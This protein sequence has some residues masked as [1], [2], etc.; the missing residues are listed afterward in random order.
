MFEIL[1]EIQDSSIAKKQKTMKNDQVRLKKR[2][3]PKSFWKS[4]Q[5]LSGLNRLDSNS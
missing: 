4:N 5:K 1:K 2:S 3:V